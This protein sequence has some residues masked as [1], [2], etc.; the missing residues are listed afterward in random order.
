MSN[1]IELEA[2]YYLDKN[3]N[4]ILNKIKK[5]NFKKTEEVIEEDTYYTDKDYI[6]IKDRICLR[7]RKVDNDFLELTYKPKTDN[8]SEKYGK[9]EVNLKLLPEE[10]EDIKYILEELGF[11]QYVSFKKHRIIYS[12]KM[13]NVQYN[14]MIDN[15]NQI[16]DF[17]ELEILVDTEKQKEEFH[18]ELDNFVKRMDCDKLREK[19]KPYRDIVKDY[20][21]EWKHRIRKYRYSKNKIIGSRF[22]GKIWISR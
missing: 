15:I 17:I 3:Y 19:E 14:I 1:R 20:I 7:T 11:I 4:E 16:G 21:N 5:E 18:D 13:K 10:S 12:K 6:F 22:N 2:S 8:K 9:R